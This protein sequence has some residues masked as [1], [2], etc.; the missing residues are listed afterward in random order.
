MCVKKVVLCVAMDRNEKTTFLIYFVSRLWSVMHSHWAVVLLAIIGSSRGVK[1]AAKL[2]L[3]KTSTPH[4]RLPVDNLKN[5]FG[6]SSERSIRI[7]FVEAFKKLCG[8]FR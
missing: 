2:K 1:N 3:D 7:T 5:S 8:D 6:E 4:H